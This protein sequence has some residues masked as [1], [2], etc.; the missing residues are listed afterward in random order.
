MPAPL[1]CP[2]HSWTGGGRCRTARNGHTVPHARN[3]EALTRA[4]AA[5]ARERLG[6]FD[7]PIPADDLAACAAYLRAV[8][9]I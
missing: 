9:T 8:A 5:F 4:V 2:V 6:K 7:L 3:R 1:S